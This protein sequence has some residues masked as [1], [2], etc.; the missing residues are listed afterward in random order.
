[1][2]HALPFLSHYV[3]S[4]L[5]WAKQQVLYNEFKRAR[6]LLREAELNP[7]RLIKTKGS[8][9]RSER[10]FSGMRRAA[11]AGI[12][13]EALRV[14][15]A[16]CLPACPPA[17]CLGKRKPSCPGHPTPWELLIVLSYNYSCRLLIALVINE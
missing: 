2:T 13:A 8:L 12:R 14:T 1:M 15:A 11:G 9:S 17:W 6:A 10:V 5:S 16:A 7:V 4:I 3:C